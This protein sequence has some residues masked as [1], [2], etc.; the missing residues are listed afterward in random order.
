VRRLAA[1]FPHLEDLVAS[2]EGSD[3]DDVSGGKGGASKGSDKGGHAAKSGDGGAA[4]SGG[5]GQRRDPQRGAAGTVGNGAVY[6]AHWPES[7]V[8]E[9]VLSGALF[10]GTLRCS[11]TAWDECYVVV[12]G[13]AV[14]AAAGGD[15][16]VSVSTRELLLYP[17]ASRVFYLFVLGR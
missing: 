3:E 8:A 14:G 6:A 11:R 13:R 12:G 2:F 5:S 17:K 4:A 7:K 1:T 10:Q 15:E 9:G 16:R